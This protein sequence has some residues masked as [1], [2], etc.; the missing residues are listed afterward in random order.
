MNRSCMERFFLYLYF[1]QQNSMK[2]VLVTG[3]YGQLAQC[4]KEIID[5]NPLKDYDFIFKDKDSFDLFNFKIIED[6][7]STN[8]VHAVI[9]CAAYTA[10]DKA[11]DDVENAFKVNADAVGYLAKECAKQNAIFIHIST[12]YVFDGNASQALQED[13]L[14]NPQNVYGKS[15]LEGER[16]ALDYNPSSIIIRTAWVYSQYGKNFLKTMLH[17]FD[18]KDEISVVEDQLGTP[19]NANDIA[20]AILKI[21][22][23]ENKKPGIFN[24]TNAGQASWFDFANE[25]KKQTGAQIKINPISTAAYPTPAKRPKF[26]VLDNQKII[27]TYQVKQ[28]EWKDALHEVLQKISN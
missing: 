18:E 7:F 2:K 5:K 26:S 14:T 22:F 21:L 23:S 27:K 13:D 10:V 6:Y 19:T 11:E 25:I 8:K 9:N 24:F 12:D 16:L 17:L 1:S 28:S 15:K 3:G 20:K 4:I